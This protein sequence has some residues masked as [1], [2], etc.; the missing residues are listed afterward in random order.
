MVPLFETLDDL[1]NSEESLRNLLSSQWYRDLINGTQEVMIGYSDSGKDAGRL[2]AA[3]GLY[4]VQVRHRE[5]VPPGLAENE[6][7]T[8]VSGASWRSIV[9][10]LVEPG[11]CIIA[12]ETDRGEAPELCV[13]VLLRLSPHGQMSR[14][15]VYRLRQAGGCQMCRQDRHKTAMPACCHQC[16]LQAEHAMPGAALGLSQVQASC[17]QQLV[18]CC[19]NLP[20]HVWPWQC[21]CSQGAGC[22]PKLPMASAALA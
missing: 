13:C 7:L 19:I 10:M 14:Q 18:F 9:S 12:G 15:H 16:C 22:W 11:G 2:A 21:G 5:I 1:H 20:T 4:E 17:R 3:W 6:A 8:V